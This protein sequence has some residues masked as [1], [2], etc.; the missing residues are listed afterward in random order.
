MT[1]KFFIDF[2]FL[3]ENDLQ[4]TKTKFVFTRRKIP[5]T[6]GAYYPDTDTVQIDLS[7]LS[8]TGSDNFRVVVAHEL[9]HRWQYKHGWVFNC[10]LPYKE[11]KHEIDARE[12]AFEF[13]RN[14]LKEK[15]Y[16]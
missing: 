16:I 8:M 6:L 12:Y 4:L 1:E 13:L 9:R 15:L 10:K 11:R 7:C 14:H 3:V 5:K 2:A